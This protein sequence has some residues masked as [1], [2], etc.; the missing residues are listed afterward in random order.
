M[1]I[2]Q[3]ERVDHLQGLITWECA[4][5][6]ETNDSDVSEVFVLCK[7]CNCRSGMEHFNP[8]PYCEVTEHQ[9]EHD[10]NQCEECDGRGFVCS[11]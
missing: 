3:I 1:L 2:T 4:N 6:Q 7:R 11:Y 10:P 5:C 9:D 8:C